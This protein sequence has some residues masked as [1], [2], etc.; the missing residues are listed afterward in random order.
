VLRCL[1]I[2]TLLG[3]M[4]ASGAQTWRGKNV[5]FG[6]AHW[7]SACRKMQRAKARSI[8]ATSRC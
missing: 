8:L 5:Y 4:P 1:V 2:G 6:D 3:A 7:H